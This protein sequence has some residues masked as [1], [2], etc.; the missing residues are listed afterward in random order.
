[1]YFAFMKTWQILTL[2]AFF[3]LTFTFLTVRKIF[4]H[5][6]SI[7]VLNFP[8]IGICYLV[9]PEYRIKLNDEGFVYYGGKNIGEVSFVRGEINPTFKKRKMGEF[10][11]GYKKVKNYRMVQYDAGN[12][13]I[14]FEKYQFIKKEPPNLQPFQEGCSHFIELHG[15]LELN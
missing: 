8:K 5:T 4:N 9:T 15:Q 12:G 11:A 1:M 3:A 2:I 6:A 7:K 13:N 10:N 14:V